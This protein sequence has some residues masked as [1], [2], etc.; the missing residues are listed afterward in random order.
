MGAS[1]GTILGGLRCSEQVPGSRCKQP[2]PS[3]PVIA[4]QRIGVYRCRR[5]GRRHAFGGPINSFLQSLSRACP[6]DFREPRMT[7][8]EVPQESSTPGPLIRLVRDQRVAF[9]VVGG[10][11]TV[12]GFAF[13]VACSETVGHLIDHRFGKV[14][15]SLVTVG[16]SHVLMVLFAFVMHRRFVFHVR[17]HVLRDL[18]R[19]ESVYLT[20]L[21]INVV[22]LPILVELGL[23]R[24]PAQAIIVAFTTLLSYFGHRHFS[25]RR[26]AAETADQRSHT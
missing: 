20:A 4:A 14:A 10:I 12:V 17:G 19:F 6:V 11:N 21:G 1:N 2:P 26:G 22:A 15:G 5:D 8:F 25:F 7:E 13:F 3:K 23:P 9:L 24:I 18:V 16:I